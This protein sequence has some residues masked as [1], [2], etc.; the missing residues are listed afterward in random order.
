M[1]QDTDTADGLKQIADIL[2]VGK[3][4]PIADLMNFKLVELDRGHAVFE[5]QPD[6]SVY[7]PIG[8]VHG[9]YAATLLD[10]AC[11]FATHSM[12]KPGQGYTTLELKVSYIKGLSDKSGTIRAQAKLRSIG[13]RVAFADAE[14]HDEA[15]RL[16]ATA[17]S[18]L[19]VFDIPPKRKT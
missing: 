14:L 11:G 6:A 3:K 5:G 1:A 4:A 19:L 17:T 16:C 10:S 9:G 8:S 15:G 13:S 12:L 2:A 18:T 7:N